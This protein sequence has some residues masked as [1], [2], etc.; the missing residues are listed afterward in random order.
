[1]VPLPKS[2]HDVYHSG[3]DKILPRQKGTQYYEQLDGLARQQMY[4]DLADYTKAFDAKY[5]TKLYD[6]MLKEG[7]PAP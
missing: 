2:I 1:L 4:R 3:L 7:F 5:G 6:A